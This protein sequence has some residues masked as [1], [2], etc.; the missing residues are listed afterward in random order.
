MTSAVTNLRQGYIISRG[1]DF[2]WF[3]VLPFVALAIALASE[4]YLPAYLTVLIAFAITTPHQG[5]TFLRVYASPIEFRRWNVRF[6]A[7]PLIIDGFSG[8]GAA[9]GLGDPVM[10][11]GETNDLASVGDVLS[12]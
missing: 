6:I 12:S 7:G 8:N 11:P 3:L 10:L 9:T 4:K 5:V 2:V 1:N